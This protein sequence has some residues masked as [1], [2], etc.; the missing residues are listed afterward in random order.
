MKALCLPPPSPNIHEIDCFFLNRGV[1]KLELRACEPWCVSWIE[2]RM[3]SPNVLLYVHPAEENHSTRA[4]QLPRL[5]IFGCNS[6]QDALYY[7]HGSLFT[8]M[9]YITSRGV[10]CTQHGARLSLY[11]HQ[12]YRMQCVTWTSSAAGRNRVK[13]V[14]SS[15]QA[16]FSCFSSECCTAVSSALSY[17]GCF[18]GLK[19]L[20]QRYGYY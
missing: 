4:F 20:V 14:L 5:K 8:Y 9:I 15:S 16:D 2:I 3:Y 17:L 12:H 19:Q 13:V 11:N 10:V 1:G 6:V 7:P 18:Q